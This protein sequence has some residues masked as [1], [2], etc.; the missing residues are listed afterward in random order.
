ML[1]R[2]AQ[3]I[4]RHHMFPHAS[5]VGIAVSG[6]ADSVFLL[7]ALHALSPLWNLELSVV[8][9]EHGIRGPESIADA[10]FVRQ[11]AASFAMPFHI[12]SANVP[13]IHDNQEQ[14]ARRVRQKFFTGL[15]AA[16]AV[17]RIATGHTRSDQA[18]TVLYRILRGSGLAGLSG[19]YPVTKEGVVRPLL[20]LS[21][22]EIEAWL[23]ERNISWREDDT[24]QNLSLRPQSP[25]PRNSSSPPRSTQPTPGRNPLQHGNRG[26]RRRTLL[27]FNTATSHRHPRNSPT[28]HRPQR[29]RPPPDPPRHRCTSK[30]D[31]R[32]ID[33]AHVERVLEMATIGEGARP[34]PAPGPGCSTVLRLDPYHS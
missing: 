20:D 11:L 10:D 24:N 2:I 9:I 30:G 21:R 27:G 18:E 8:H 14:A 4:A 29:R 26:Q 3:F 23:G 15:M 31:L 34:H 19:I 28:N 33:F 7:H 6:G 1:D 17:D 16:G 32:Q 12:H 5:R 13:A 25:A 22:A